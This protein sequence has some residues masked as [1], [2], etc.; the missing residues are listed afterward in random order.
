MS[1]DI[2]LGRDLDTHPPKKVYLHEKTRSTHMQVIG[3]TGTGKSKFLEHLI[4]AD[5]LNGDGLCLIDPHGYL[6]DDLVNWLCSWPD[7]FQYKKIVLF[8]P[9]D[10]DYFLGFNPFIHHSLDISHQVDTMV[11]ACAKAWG[12]ENM[13]T[14]PLLKN[15]CAVSSTLWLKLI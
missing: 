10:D 3:S 13:D 12:A 2:L 14:T 15:A 9:A 6:Y 1:D 5:I 8:N 7:F 11:N 4:R